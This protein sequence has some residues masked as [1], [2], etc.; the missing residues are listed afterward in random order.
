MLLDNLI[1]Y[2]LKSFDFS[3]VKVESKELQGNPLGDPTIR[4]NMVLKPKNTNDVQEVVFIL[5]GYGGDGFKNFSFK[6]FEYNLVQDID[7]WTS[8]K[9]IPAAYYVFVNAWTKWGGSQFINSKGAGN[10]ENYI[11]KELLPEFKKSLSISI[12]ELR[13]S[14]FGGSSGGYGALHLASQYPEVFT[15]AVAQAPDSFFKLSLLPEIYKNLPYIYE[16]ESLEHIYK[17]LQSGR[18]RWSSSTTFSVLNLI[19]MA[20]CYAPLDPKSKYKYSFPINR[21]GI[22]DKK[23]WQEWERHDP[24]RFLKDR[25]TNIKKLEKIII[26]TGDKDEYSLQYGSRQIETILNDMGA[27]ISYTELP[28][29][30]RSIS[31]F[32]EKTLI[33][34]LK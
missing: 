14:V 6:P 31:K 11:V 24:L 23:I 8:E 9:I 26:C 1:P 21:L 22:L 25:K 15:K 13:F 18:L 32:R 7:R 27:K 4:L 19:A 33:D 2:N 28:G 12:G 17:E 10:Y 16:K 34:L 20:S 3:T 30:H 5:S 29:T